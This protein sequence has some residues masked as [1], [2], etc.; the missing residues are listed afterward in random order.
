MRTLFRTYFRS[1]ALIERF[2]AELL[3][4]RMQNPSRADFRGVAMVASP[5]TGNCPSYRPR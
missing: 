4:H 2:A 3:H 5:M 1:D